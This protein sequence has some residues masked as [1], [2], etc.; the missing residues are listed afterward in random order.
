MSIPYESTSVRV[1]KSIGDMKILLSEIGFSG[2]GHLEE[3][4]S[5]TFIGKVHGTSFKWTSDADRI[6]AKI[7]QSKK[8]TQVSTDQC[9]RIAWRAIYHSVAA[10]VKNI[11]CGATSIVQEFGALAALS[12]GVTVGDMVLEQIENGSLKSLPLLTQ[13]TGAN[14]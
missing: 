11:Q 13:T 14:L 2:F 8:R 5:H 3:G 9:N 1:D 7:R 6:A 12:D 4:G 10:Q